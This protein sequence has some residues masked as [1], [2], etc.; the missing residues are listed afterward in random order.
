MLVVA[1]PDGG[2]MD[3]PTL[4]VAD[5]VPEL[6]LEALLVEV[7]GD[8]RPATLL[9]YVRNVVNDAPGDY[10]W[11]APDAYFVVWHC[12]EAAD[13]HANGVWLDRGQ[14]KAQLRNRH[15]W[16]LGAYVAG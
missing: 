10:P 9:G 13:V 3:I 12:R 2:G 8:V 5:D 4:S 6:A 11:P 16:P 7:L 1:R 15:W 14:A